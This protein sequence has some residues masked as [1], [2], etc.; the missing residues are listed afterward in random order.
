MPET[1]TRLEAPPGLEAKCVARGWP[2]QASVSRGK[3]VVP[4]PEAAST[5]TQQAAVFLFYCK[6][7]NKHTHKKNQNCE[8]TLS[9]LAA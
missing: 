4:A 7:E 5:P 2:G 6:A 3:A 9:P 8:F 1:P